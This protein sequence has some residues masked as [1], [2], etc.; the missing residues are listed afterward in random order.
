VNPGSGFWGA[1]RLP[2]IDSDSELSTPFS[3]LSYYYSVCVLQYSTVRESPV[4]LLLVN[5]EQNKKKRRAP[6]PNLCELHN[7]NNIS[8]TIYNF[9]IPRLVFSWG[10][11]LFLGQLAFVHL[12]LN[13]VVRRGRG[14]V[15]GQVSPE[16]SR[17]FLHMYV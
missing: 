7:N 5:K 3:I 14:T 13:S 17:S 11:N 9:V 15:S 12:N 2:S 6:S 1:G 4:L 8:C 10:K 16:P